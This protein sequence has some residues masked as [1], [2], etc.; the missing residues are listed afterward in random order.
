MNEKSNRKEQHN[1]LAEIVKSVFG[2]ATNSYRCDNGKYVVILGKGK[3]IGD[4]SFSE[5]YLSDYSMLF[6]LTF[7]SADTSFE[8]AGKR[9]QGKEYNRDIALRNAIRYFSKHGINLDYSF[10]SLAEKKLFSKL[11]LSYINKILSVIFNNSKLSNADF[12]AKI[13]STF[14]QIK[15]SLSKQDIIYLMYSKAS[16]SDIE[17]INDSAYDPYEYDKA[18]SINLANTTNHLYYK[19]SVFRPIIIKTKKMQD[20]Y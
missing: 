5:K 14:K 9:Y 7:V 3:E 12:R 17:R 15:I 1:C 8:Y 6:K 13:A 19:A 2:T 18:F 11:I 20:Q 16:N 4:C 10:C